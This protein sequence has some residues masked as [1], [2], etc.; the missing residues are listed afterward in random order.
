[1]YV[2]CVRRINVAIIVIAT[3]HRIVYTNLYIYGVNRCGK[4]AYTAE[5]LYWQCKMIILVVY[6]LTW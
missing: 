2:I 1:M 4:A 3:V 5:S 6:T